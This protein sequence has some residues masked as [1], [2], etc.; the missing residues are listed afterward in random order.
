[1]PDHAPL[2]QRE[3]EEHADRV[4]RNKCVSVPAE[5][6]EEQS[7]EGSQD[8]DAVGKDEAITEFRKLARHVAVSGE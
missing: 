8:E 2:R 1:M 5:N 7:S 3:G 4:E 6:N